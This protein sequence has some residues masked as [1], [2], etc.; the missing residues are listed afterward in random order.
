MRTATLLIPLSLMLGCSSGVSSD[1][2]AELA[3]LGLSKAV[4]NGMDLGFDGFNA[5]DSANIPEQQT[6]GDISG[7]ML[8]SGQ[9][10]QGVSDN[11]GMRLVL[12][13]DEYSDFVDLDS[14]EDREISITYWTDPE[15]AL[16]TLQLQLRGIPDGTFE[17]AL[18]GSFGM[19]GDLEGEVALSVQL[20]GGLES[21]DA[22]G[23]RREPGSTTIIG[24]ARGPSGRV[25]DVDL[26]L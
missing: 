23:T 3:Y 2:E 9:V 19:D 17:G 8:V 14:D 5:A 25:Y 26:S 22:G 4:Q 7:T 15:V 12:A 24:T 20:A 11:K 10:D 1:E 21:D 13:L 16:P 6:V 18:V